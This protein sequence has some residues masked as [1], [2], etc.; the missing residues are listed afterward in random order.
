MTQYRFKQDSPFESATDLKNH[1]DID[2]SV[3]AETKDIAVERIYE[4]VK[5]FGWDRETIETCIEEVK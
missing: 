2:V 3:S 5:R 4:M 1:P